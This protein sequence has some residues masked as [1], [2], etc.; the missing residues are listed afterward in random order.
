[1]LREHSPREFGLNT[2]DQVGGG[3]GKKLG[4]GIPSRG[5]EAEG[6]YRTVAGN[7]ERKQ[8]MKG[9]MCPAD[10]PWPLFQG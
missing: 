4:K 3:H 8:F 1:M 10:K 9:P 2:E 6:E 5:I 7:D